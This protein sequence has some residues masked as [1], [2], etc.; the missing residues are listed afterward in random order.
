M[1]ALNR[2]LVDSELASLK[3]SLIHARLNEAKINKINS[4]QSESIEDKMSE[5]HF[6]FRALQVEIGTHRAR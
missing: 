4:D 6:A 1:F 3:L 2:T 5:V